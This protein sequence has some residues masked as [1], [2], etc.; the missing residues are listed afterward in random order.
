MNDAS[1]L[2]GATV[3]D[4][5]EERRRRLD[6]FAQRV[7]DEARAAPLPKPPT[8]N[9]RPPPPLSSQPARAAP[10]PK[11]VPKPA[12]ATTATSTTTPKGSAPSKPSTSQPAKFPPALGLVLAAMAVVGL[13]TY[14]NSQ[15]PQ[16]SSPPYQPLPPAEATDPTTPPGPW[17]PPADPAASD[18]A[19]TAPVP[20]D[21]SYLDTKTD[22]ELRSIAIYSTDSS[23][24]EEANKRLTSR[25]QFAYGGAQQSFGNLVRF[26][27]AWQGSQYTIYATS[28][29][30]NL[31][32]ARK[33]AS[34]ANV[35]IT[36]P[37]NAYRSPTYEAD[38]LSFSSTSGAYS[39]TGTISGDDS[40]TWVELS[41]N[42]QQ[43]VI[44]VYVP[45]SAISYSAPNYTSLPASTPKYSTAPN[46][47]AP[48]PATSEPS[49]LTLSEQWVS[50][51]SDRDFRRITGKMQIRRSFRITVDCQ[52]NSDYR[53]TNCETFDATI[54]VTQRQ[55]D[56]AI[57]LASL[58][59]APTTADGYSTQQRRTE[60]TF[61][62]QPD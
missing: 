51:P 56:G 17:P 57:E 30:A 62:F 12:A 27:R 38:N 42:Y 29:L 32:Q 37:T 3:A 20:L 24:V 25:E 14:I 23:E 44:S 41:V 45:A 4:P 40:S 35:W 60:I 52:V 8:A 26:I 18:P 50:Q 39:S 43:A 47:A 15:T 6:E 7:A 33:T 46:N 5:R 22:D 9:V 19:A 34:V 16:T 54:N 2:D 31:L 55:I 48:T 10:R 21:Y 36:Q 59:V 53:L 49:Y 61:E 28:D 13:I 11:P 58:Y 1:G